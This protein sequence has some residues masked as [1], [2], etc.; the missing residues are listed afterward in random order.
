MAVIR[1]RDTKS[2]VGLVGNPCSDPF[3]LLCVV[4]LRCSK[5]FNFWHAVQLLVFMFCEEKF[6]SHPR[7]R[8]TMK[9]L[10][11]ETR[12]DLLSGTP[13]FLEMMPFF[14]HICECSKLTPT[15]SLTCLLWTQ[16]SSGW[17]FLLLYYR[18]V[19]L[20]L[21]EHIQLQWCLKINSRTAGGVNEVVVW[22]EDMEPSS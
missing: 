21:T 13:V 3:L 12:W 20:L 22:V 4:S 11:A 19:C 6:Q 5:N 7:F 16:R 14:L 1:D 10:T 2:K 15:V 18:F 9:T 17:L 8:T